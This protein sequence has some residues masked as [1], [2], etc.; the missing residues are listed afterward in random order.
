MDN[1]TSLS[2]VDM[3]L[4]AGVPGPPPQTPRTPGLFPRR[5]ASTVRR[6]LMS[7]FDE[8]DQTVQAP[9][10]VTPEPISASTPEVVAEPAEMF[11]CVAIPK[12]KWSKF[13]C[14]WI[15]VFLLGCVCVSA[16]Y[17]YFPGYLLLCFTKEFLVTGCLG[18][19]CAVL[20]SVVIKL[21]SSD[22]DY[23]EERHVT[24]QQPRAQRR[25][26]TSPGRRE[27][28]ARGNYSYS[29]MNES[30]N[31]TVYQI[32]VKRTFSGDGKDIW[33]EYATYFEN[34]SSLN[35]WSED[36]K[37]RVFFTMLRGQAETFAYG[38][39]ATERNSWDNLKL[40]MDARFGHKAMKESYVAEAKLRRKK[41]TESFRDFG[42]AIQDLYRRAYPDNAEYVQESSMKTFM[43]N[44]SEIDDFRLAVKRTRPRTLQ[45]AVTAAM[46][47]EC[48]RVSEDRKSQTNRVQRRPIYNMRW[49]WRN[50]DNGRTSP[51]ANNDNIQQVPNQGNANGN[52]NF[53]P[54][55]RCFECNS[56]EHL[57][58]DCPNKPNGRNNGRS[59]TGNRTDVKTGTGSSNSGRPGQ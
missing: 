59:G 43:D 7:A 51:K 56:T 8:S 4:T 36:R 2:P 25:R 42:Q 31:T 55:K 37:R 57:Y 30:S 50:N 28:P 1:R 10:V 54:A 22:V 6:N 47:E 39:S 9:G 3:E 24:P 15:I 45:E 27:T 35:E 12:R 38:L 26:S 44:C 48:I 32:Q 34:I 21:V 20:I 53:Q 16:L 46:Q 11:N 49:N 23:T 40:A 52:R 5:D 58:K 19:L 18:F 41:N 29:N 13:I 33:S 17:M 14:V